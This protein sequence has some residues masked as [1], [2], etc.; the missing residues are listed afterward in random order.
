MKRKLKSNSKM[1]ALS[2]LEKLR[3][4]IKN[5]EQRILESVQMDNWSIEPRIVSDEE[6]CRAI[7]SLPEAK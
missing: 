3:R 4:D 1:L 2:R 7:Y 5:L 6:E